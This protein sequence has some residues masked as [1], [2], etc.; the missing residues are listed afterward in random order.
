M[1]R[2]IV[3]M[4]Y[5]SIKTFLGRYI[6][7]MLIVALSAGF[8]AGLKITQKTMVNTC[9]DYFVRQNMYD[10]RI[11]STIGFGNEDVESFEKLDGVK[12]VEATKSL[13]MLIRYKNDE[14]AYK[15]MAITKKINIPSLVTGR[16][17]SKDNECLV[18]SE[19][20]GR[21]DIGKTIVV[22]NDNEAATLEQLDIKEYT[23]V[24]IVDSPLYINL[25]RGTTKI[26]NGSLDSFVYVPEAN[27]TSD[28]F[29]ELNI[30]L[31]ETAPIYSEEYDD[32]IEKYE[33]NV[34]SLAKERAL[35]R[36][37]N[38]LREK[39]LNEDMAQQMGFA[40]PS[41]YV[42]T[43]AENVGYVS[44]ENDS[45]IISAVANIFPIF[46]IV[47][48]LLVCVTTMSRMVDEERTQIGV[49]KA[50]GY[51]N[52]A[53]TMKYLLYSGSATFIGWFIG[54]FLCTW[55]LPEIFWLAYNA[56][57]DF[58][59]LIYIFD[60]MLALL[61]LVVSLVAILGSA[62][63]SCRKELVEVPAQMIRP[64]N[65][66]N[67]K[68]ILLERITPLWKGL[69]F[70][71]KITLRN[72]FRYKQRLFMMLV[73]ISCC[74]GLVVTA[75]GVRDSMIHI[76]SIQFGD[77][78]AY[79]M[80]AVFE[81]EYS[82][83]LKAKLDELEGVNEY[84]FANKQ[85]VELI[86]TTSLSSV[87][88]ISIEDKENFTKYWN[89]YNGDKNV[90]LP[91][92]NKV[93]INQK[94]ADKFDVS[95]GDTITIRD[96]QMKEYELIIGGIF[97]N[98]INNYVIINKE[99]YEELFGDWTNN[100]V[101]INTDE[102]TEKLAK[103]LIE[104]PGVVNITRLDAM[105]QGV[106]DVI[107]CL[108]YI[109]WL[110]VFFSGALAFIVIYNLT[111]INIAERSREIATVQVLGFYPKE[112]ESYV[113]R[114]NLV[115]SIIASFI[116]L[117]LGR[118]FHYV[119]M[120]MVTIDQFTFKNVVEPLSYVLGLFFTILFAVIVNAFMKKQIDKIHMAESLKAVE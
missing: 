107:G 54:F 82:T 83:E 101:Y 95:V 39:G 9:D 104:E 117:P 42:L 94:I 46:F 62:F 49:L 50:M 2:S 103:T 119:V 89:L 74:A 71:Q 41:V 85:T 36:Y 47:I 65:L 15:V 99:Y 105:R 110:V 96:S 60:P 76:G 58:A 68:R 10:Y 108:N 32:I 5:R 120:T 29:T 51:K 35:I 79:S 92:G 57:Y 97:E 93:L 12:D 31:N 37:G 38:I 81:T 115:L 86:G 91:S 78:Q 75:F 70:L 14:K 72:M 56:I 11:F 102:D 16:M 8:F 88:L 20:F 113:L 52:S 23:I 44:F 64:R 116:G 80:E 7:L 22:S 77:I 21:A 40:G 61:T 17:P 4:T 114:E 55:G 30:T 106:D 111:N 18:D 19:D 45:S 67:G 109:I 25:D 13:D 84:Y 69:S 112:T 27:F 53:I 24:G 26:G 98:H 100:I 63:I 73:G 6:A 90:E 28:V 48:A 33:E 66:K 59:P 3:K 1:K 118:A 87:S 43:R 34:L